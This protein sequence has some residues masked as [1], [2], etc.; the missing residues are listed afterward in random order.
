MIADADQKP[1][2]P[3]GASFA[4]RIDGPA[5]QK[6]SVRHGGGRTFKSA[7]TVKDMGYIRLKAEGSWNYRPIEDPVAFLIYVGQA[8]PASFSKKKRAGLLMQS[9]ART[10]DVDNVAKLYMD[11]LNGLVWKDDRQVS[12]LLV[13][14]VWRES[15]FVFLSAY[16]AH[17]LDLDEVST[18]LG[19]EPPL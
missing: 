8:L 9:C 17:D 6:N 7:R 1:E 5:S 16:R 3:E 2:A 11:C 14:R 18:F 19:M 10:P 12:T 15:S 4:I 13:R